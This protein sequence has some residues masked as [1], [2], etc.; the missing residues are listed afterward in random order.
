MSL[1]TNLLVKPQCHL[2]VVFLALLQHRD[3]G[4]DE[5]ETP[6]RFCWGKSSRLVWVGAGNHSENRLVMPNSD[7]VEVWQAVAWD[8]F[9]VWIR[10]P[11]SHIFLACQSHRTKWETTGVWRFRFAWFWLQRGKSTFA[12]KGSKVVKFTTFS[13]HSAFHIWLYDCP[14]ML[15]AGNALWWQ[16]AEPSLTD[17]HHHR[18][19]REPSSC[20]PWLL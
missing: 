4:T 18:V 13:S 7:F 14:L 10:R 12:D 5:L 1:H 19:T 20:L 9:I 17:L 6:N 2:S 11:S 3:S 8:G 15:G 16:V